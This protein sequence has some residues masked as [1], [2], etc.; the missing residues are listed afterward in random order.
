MSVAASTIREWRENPRKF[1]ADN[2]RVEPDV[3][4]GEA[5]DE[6]GG[7]W[8]PRRRLA[9]KA[10]TGPGK[11][12]VLAW[13]GWHRLSCFGDRE[14]HPK[15]AALSG[16]GADNLRDNLWA[17]LAIWQ[18]RSP[19]L[20]A[21]FTHHAERV[22]ANDHP[23]TWFLSARSYAKDADSEA[24]GRS[25][26]GLHSKYPFVLLDEIGDA[27]TTLG[28]K[29]EQIFTGG[30][31]DAL[32]A[33]A[34]N[35]TS[36]TGLLYEIATALRGLWKVITI[37]ADPDDP[38]RTPRV[39]IDL[40]REQ[41]K[42]YGRDNPWVMATILGEFPPAGFNQLISL[43]DAEAAMDRELRHDVY[44]WSQK[45]LGVDV[46]RFG[47]DRTVLA[48]RQGLRW[49]VPVVMRNA[50]TTEIAARMALAREKWTRAEQETKDLVEFV[51]DTGGY[52]G[53]VIDSYIQAGHSCI[54]VN[55]GGKADDPRFFNKRTEMWFRMGELVKRSQLPRDPDLIRE[56]TAPT[57]TF[58][59]GKFR[60]EEKDQIKK[61]LP[62]IGSPDK[63]DAFALTCA[64]V[65]MPA[66]IPAAHPAFGTQAHAMREYDPFDPE[67]K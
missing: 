48:P 8:N 15:G 17:E 6:L 42:L 52:G 50:R 34:G 44:N 11:S 36:T 16:E 21:A 45:R 65:D 31:L 14:N 51:D 41:I 47:D 26:S 60:L 64:H 37:T 49:F 57:Y 58:Q 3:W 1:V 28:Q 5:L 7:Q 25:L 63:A 19:F 12:T 23:K 35:P 20:T 56:L 27:P 24:V 67:R 39:P 22:F 43:A 30:A 4:Q 32:I 29:A 53:G 18:A 9:M 33:G 62:K 66:M 13:A 54:P 38:K 59:G 46:A 55:F 10:C 40:A 2:F 61:R